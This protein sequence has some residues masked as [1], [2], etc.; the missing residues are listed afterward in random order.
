MWPSDFPIELREY[1]DRSAG[2]GCHPDLQMYARED[3]DLEFVV[4]L[5]NDSECEVTFYDREQKKHMVKPKA[6]SLFMV[7]PNS[8]THCVSATKGGSRTILKF[9]F[10]GD[11]TKGRQFAM[12]TVNECGDDNPNNQ[13]LLARRQGSDKGYE[14][15][16]ARVSREREPPGDLIAREYAS[17]SG[18]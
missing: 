4:T 16:L 10:V 14:T 12:Y 15:R 11:Y 3:L 13:M 17:L 7:R 6:N 9:I 8:A 5:D 2:M 1:G 18:F